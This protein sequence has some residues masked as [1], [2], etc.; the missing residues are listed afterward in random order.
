M[1]V[2]LIGLAQ[3]GKSAVF[4][5]LGGGVPGEGAGG[6]SLQVANIK[7]PDERLDKLAEMFNPPKVVHADIDFMDVAG[8]RADQ[9]GAGL[10]PQIVIEVRTADALIVT[11]RAF[12]NP[13]VVHPLGSVDPV[14]DAK[15]VEAELTLNDLIQVEKRLQRMEKEHSD[16]LEKELLIRAKTLLDEEKPLRLLDVS[17][18][19]EGII[20]GFS[21]LSRKPLLLLLNV[22]EGDIGR[23]PY[24]EADGFAAAKGYSLAR[25]CAEIEAEIAELEQEEQAAFLEELGLDKSGRERL[26]REVYRLL[27]LVSF[28]TIGDTEIRA[29]SIPEGTNAVVAAGKIHSDMERGFIRAEV[30]N[31]DMLMQQG[32]MQSAKESGRLRLEGKDSLICDG[33][34]VKFRFHV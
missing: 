11:V 1:K 23:N 4:R 13:A 29:W 14:R 21:F 15:N 22:S 31:F 10:S 5:S 9:K 3:S 6:H 12:E 26:I 17:P 33:D 32:S 27:R 25:Y 20:A 28:F 19:E 18:V 24:P 8:G 2:A 34:I 16:G 30:I 7:V